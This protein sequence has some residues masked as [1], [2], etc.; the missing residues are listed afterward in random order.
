[1]P[2]RTQLL[3]YGLV[4]FLWRGFGQT[5]ITTSMTSS[6]TRSLAAILIGWWVRL[7]YRQPRL[8]KHLLVLGILGVT[9]E[10]IGIKTCFPYSCFEY[11]TQL[12]PQLFGTFPLL[13]FFIRPTI[14]LS[15]AP[16]LTSKKFRPNL[17]TWVGLLV[18]LDLFLDPVS[19]AK[20][21]WSY[22]ITTWRFGVPWDN[23]LW[24]IFTGLIS[25]SILLSISKKVDTK[26]LIPKNVYVCLCLRYLW[27]FLYILIG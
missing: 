15:I 1:M 21:F 12:G 23:Y 27:A 6:S 10:Y 4:L 14:C 19:V 25:I 22:T 2:K 8:W 16:F 11:S 9:I 13:L 5:E 24:W 7:I 17:T 3:L 26:N 20:W 18:F